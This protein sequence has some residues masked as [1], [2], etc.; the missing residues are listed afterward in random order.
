MKRRDFLALSA[1][2][3][4]APLMAPAVH[5]QQKKFSGVTLRINGYGGT[6][7]KALIE[8]VAKPLEESTGLKIEYI[9]STPS[10]DIAK[11]ISNKN[12]PH[13]DMFMADSPLMPQA[14]AGDILESFSASDAP[15][16]S[17][18]L[19]G[20]REF[21][22]YG[23][24][25][26]VAS[27]VPVYNSSTVK[28]PLTSFSDIARPDLK[29]KVVTMPGNVFTG[30]IVLLALA[31]GNGGSLANM[32]P[33]FKLISAA[34]DNIIATPPS[35]VA[36]L[37]AFTQGEAQAGTLW[38]GRAFE[39]RKSGTPLET[40]VAREGIYAVTSYT[41]IVRGCR[42]KEAALAYINQLLSDQGM[43]AVPKALRYGPT[44]D[45]ALGDIAADILVN[46]R[47]RAALKRQIDWKAFMAQGPAL[48]ERM[49]KELR[50]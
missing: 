24:P 4:L 47:E 20:F 19:P 8:G 9:P 30:W 40:V 43:L 39:A 28:P 31:E 38:D 16:L 35:S 7:D 21:G 1:T 5:A 27:I 48:G 11:L 50:G 44:T 29:G 33:A 41:N 13:L 2:A 25:F 42:N 32:E 12:N 34:K 45:V 46:S 36:Q 49:T 37:Q 18:V 6:Y 17:R 23:A 22:D 10:A 26:S 14:I 15:N 3:A